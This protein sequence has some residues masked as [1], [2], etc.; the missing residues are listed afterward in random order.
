MQQLF[1]EILKKFTPTRYSVF[2]RVWPLNR[3]FTH[4]HD[5][6]LHTK[7]SLLYKRFIQLPLCFAK[8]IPTL[9]FSRFFLSRLFYK[10]ITTKKYMQNINFP[11]DRVKSRSWIFRTW[12]VL[13]NNKLPFRELRIL[14]SFLYH[15]KAITY[16]I[17]K[18]HSLISISK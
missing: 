16:D 15:R 3:V 18:R 14:R 2:M 17:K 5:F 6:C 1:W 10:N 8:N 9:V 11:I 13:Q 12:A 7:M 4:R